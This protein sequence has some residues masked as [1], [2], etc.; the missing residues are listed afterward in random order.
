MSPSRPSVE[1]KD[2]MED[3]VLLLG[4]PSTSP[5]N[6]IPVSAIS[7]TGSAYPSPLYRKGR[8]SPF[9]ETAKKKRVSEPYTSWNALWT[10]HM[11][12][13]RRN[14]DTLVLH[15]V[16]E[17][18]YASHGSIKLL[19]FIKQRSYT[20]GKGRTVRTCRPVAENIAG[21]SEVTLQLRKDIPSS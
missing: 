15:M 13:E 19:C 9:V 21:N 18:V 16:V 12:L 2:T 20:W 8:P 6:R 5:R 3:Y 7:T 1:P 17:D 14:H 11:R 10:A 4:H